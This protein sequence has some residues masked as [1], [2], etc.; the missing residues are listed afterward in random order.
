M[1]V[2]DLELSKP[3]IVIRQT[4]ASQIGI[5]SAA[6]GFTF[7]QIVK[8]FDTSDKSSVDSYV[9][10]PTLGLS[11]IKEGVNTYYIISEELV[12]GIEIPPP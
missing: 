2:T 10:L 3:K 9:V 11:A 1:S 12:S 8:V 7:G 4:D 6:T 5:V